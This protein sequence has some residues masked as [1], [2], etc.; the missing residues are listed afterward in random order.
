MDEK[1]RSINSQPR[2][3]GKYTRSISGTEADVD[4]EIDTGKM[5]P[6][7][8]LLPSDDENSSNSPPKSA[9]TPIN[10]TMPLISLTVAQDP[11]QAQ[12]VNS[13]RN[14]QKI[15]KIPRYNKRGSFSKNSSLSSPDEEKGQNNFDN[16]LAQ[17]FGGTVSYQSPIIAVRKKPE[18]KIRIKINQKTN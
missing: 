12:I 1:Y 5:L 15:S 4:E 3:N 9:D 10:E 8:L 6:D 13:N 18:N 14:A 7:E 11:V 17:S 2:K 16:R